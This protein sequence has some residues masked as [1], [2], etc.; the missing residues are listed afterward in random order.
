[1]MIVY[2]RGDKNRLKKDARSVQKWIHSR[3]ISMKLWRLCGAYSVTMRMSHA[4]IRT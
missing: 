1:M 3:R 4:V 2:V